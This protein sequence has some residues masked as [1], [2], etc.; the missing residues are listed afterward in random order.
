MVGSDRPD[1]LIIATKAYDTMEAVSECRRL[2]TEHTKVLTRQN[3][4]GNLEL[5]R[6]WEGAHA[7]GGTTTMGAA[8]DPRGADEIAAAF[9]SWEG[10]TN[11]LQ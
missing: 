7:F 5:L 6:E 1:L 11:Y 3:G 2:T 4:L 10:D 9:S 8:L